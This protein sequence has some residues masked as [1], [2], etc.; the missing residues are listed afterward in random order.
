VVMHATSAEVSSGSFPTPA[1]GGVRAT[2]PYHSNLEISNGHFRFRPRRPLAMT[3]K[4]VDQLE[5][6]CS[7]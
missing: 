7:V 6:S 1:R 3:E 4:K 2:A 5:R